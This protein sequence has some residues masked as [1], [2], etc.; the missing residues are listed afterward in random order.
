[1]A[2]S[3]HPATTKAEILS[4]R[5]DGMRPKTDKGAY[6]IAN[7]PTRQ[8]LTILRRLPKQHTYI[9]LLK[10]KLPTDYMTSS[11]HMSMALSISARSWGGRPG[12]STC[13]KPRTIVDVA[14]SSVS[15]RDMR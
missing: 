7:S 12:M 14:S 15:P 1:M 6:V 2:S 9:G 5:P 11:R 4:I 8:N 13:R 3:P 10:M